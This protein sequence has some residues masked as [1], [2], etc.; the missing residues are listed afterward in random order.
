MLNVRTVFNLAI[1]LT[2]LFTVSAQLRAESSTSLT[3]TEKTKAIPISNYF[4]A[5]TSPEG[6]HIA[7]EKDLLPSVKIMVVGKGTYEFPPSVNLTTEVYTGTVKQYL[8]RIK[9]INLSKGSEWKDL[10]NI[11][12][13]AG[14]ASLS[15]VDKKTEW[16][17]VRMM[18]VIMKKDGNIYIMTAAARKE[19]FPN[20]Y[21]TFF[22]TFSSLR[23]ESTSQTLKQTDSY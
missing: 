15:Q 17:N 11:R 4:V 22:N 9:E 16:G 12:T 2:T 7:D 3:Q 8:K 1:L 10:G 19:E 23:F 18:H 5:F 13:Q 6:W 21:K 14:D 20:F